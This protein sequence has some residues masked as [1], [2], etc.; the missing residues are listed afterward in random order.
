MIEYDRIAESY[1]AVERVFSTYRHLVELPSFLEA[2]GPAEGLSVLDAGCGTGAYARL[3]RQRGAGRT[4]GVDS[5][6]AMIEVAR[7]LER[8]D[9]VGAEYA[10]HDIA[11]MPVLGSFDVVVA[12]AVLHYADSTATLARMCER[13]YA[14][15]K[16]GGRLLAY[17]ANP[18][19]PPGSAQMNGLV[20]SRPDDPADGDTYHLTIPT[21]PPTTLPARYWRRG[22]LEEALTASGFQDVSWEPLRGIPDGGIHPPINLLLSA[23]RN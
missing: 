7:E 2:L 6:P 22:A 11:E 8:K 21:T 15:L 17:V 20:V 1:L 4:L 3:L 23:R 16:S 13:T 9:P 14:N 18:A 19:L 10:V 12:V 5:S